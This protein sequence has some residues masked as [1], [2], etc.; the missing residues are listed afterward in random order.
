MSINALRSLIALIAL[1]FCYFAAAA[2][3]IITDNKSNTLFSMPSSL[4]SPKI[5]ANSVGLTYPFA[6]F[7]NV[8]YFVHKNNDPKQDTLHTIVKSSSYYAKVTV[9]NSTGN[10]FDFSKYFTISPHFE[11]G[12]SRSIDWF[13]DVSSL[14]LPYATYSIAAFVDYQNFNTYD[15]VAQTLP[16][17]KFRRLSPGFKAILNTFNQDNFA[18][19]LSVSYQWGV[20]TSMLSGFQSFS[21]TYYSDANVATSGPVNGYLD[22]I[23]VQNIV[24]ISLAIPFFQIPPIDL[25]TGFKNKFGGSDLQIVPALYYYLTTANFSKVEHTAGFTLNLLPYKIH[26]AKNFSFSSAINLG[27]NLIDST[28]KTNQRYVFFAGT[29]SFGTPKPLPVDNK[30][31]TNLL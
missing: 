8:Q 6:V 2:Q 28:N 12:F 25:G 17:S 27:Y 4:V 26:H 13:N 10:S 29:F 20:N 15:T 23:L 1:Q 19:A 31:S 7:R 14:K 24:R 22:P 16:Y 30:K 11:I 9:S 18:V 5:A 3:D 21:P